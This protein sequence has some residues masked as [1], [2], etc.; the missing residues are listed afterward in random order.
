MEQ[1][2]GAEYVIDPVRD[3]VPVCPNCHRMLHS[4]PGG[5]YSAEELKR[6]GKREERMRRLLCAVLCVALVLCTLCVPAFAD[7]EKYYK[8]SGMAYF[9][10]YDEE[11]T[12]VD[13]QSVGLDP[14][15][16]TGS[17]FVPNTSAAEAFNTAINEKT[18]Q[19]VKAGYTVTYV[20]T[21]DERTDGG[22]A[23]G[24]KE[25]PY[26]Y[27]RTVYYNATKGNGN[28][29]PT[30]EDYYKFSGTATFELYDNEQPVGTVVV[31]HEGAGKPETEHMKDHDE[32]DAKLAGK[33]AELEGLGYTVTRID[34]SYPDEE[35]AGTAEDVSHQTGDAGNAARIAMLAAAAALCVCARC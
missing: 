28:N 4:M 1:L 11:G 29:N 8:V 13:T 21:Q 12:L 33:I 19:L 32:F 15:L 10:L 7:E 20:R 6:L 18:M 27:I 25:D 30:V 9:K 5:V 24:S 16:L 23:G 14:V 3:L 2:F 31:N 17:E 22:S 26:T 34:Y 35:R